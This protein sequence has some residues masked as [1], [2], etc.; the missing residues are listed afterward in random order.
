MSFDLFV[1]QFYFAPSFLKETVPYEFLKP[2]DNEKTTSKLCFEAKSGFLPSAVFN[3]L[4]ASCIA[5]F[6][7]VWDKKTNQYLLFCGCGIFFFKHGLL[8]HKLFILFNE[9]AIQIWLSREREAPD[10][11]ICRQAKQ[12]VEDKIKKIC[13]EHFLKCPQTSF[14]LKDN[15]FKLK[16]KNAESLVETM[17]TVMPEQLKQ[18]WFRK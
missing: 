16:I 11:E 8:Q 1:F 7:L 6:P 13:F 2:A 17:V 4:L 15:E 18:I 14:I 5:K 3:K 10:G 9:N 12:F